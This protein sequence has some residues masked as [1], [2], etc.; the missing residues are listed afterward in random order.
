[1]HQNTAFL[2]L[3]NQ[4]DMET[5]V[6]WAEMLC[7]SYQ[8]SEVIIRLFS[9]ESWISPGQLSADITTVHHPSNRPIEPHLMIMQQCKLNLWSQFYYITELPKGPKLNHSPTKLPSCQTI[10]CQSEVVGFAI[11]AVALLSAYRNNINFINTF[12]QLLTD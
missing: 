7:K 5:K 2:I 4:R 8:N 6:Q 3:A 12:R 11:D 1:M 9:P 10:T